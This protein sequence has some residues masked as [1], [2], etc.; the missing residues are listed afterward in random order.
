MKREVLAALDAFLAVQQEQREELEAG[1]LQLLAGWDAQLQGV[2]GP[3]QRSLAVLST[4]ADLL[5]DRGFWR[6]VEERM[7]S[8]RTGG[9]AVLRAAAGQRAEVGRQMDAIRR[10][11]KAVQGYG[12]KNVTTAPKPRFLSS[13]T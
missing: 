9:A 11:R 12:A 7:A 8:I 10:G 1:R 13:R 5:A 6:Q 2:F 4:N 3:A